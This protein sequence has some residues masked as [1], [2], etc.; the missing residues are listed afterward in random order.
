MSLTKHRIVEQLLSEFGFPN[1]QSV[2]IVESI[3]ETIKAT[4]ESGEDSLISGFGKFC[5]RE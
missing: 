2:E 3:L 4:L 1:N 5:V